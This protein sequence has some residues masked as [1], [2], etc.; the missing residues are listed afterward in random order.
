MCIVVRIS[1]TPTP[2]QAVFL[3]ATKSRRLSVFFDHT[4]VTFRSE[5][6]TAG[7][8]VL[9]TDHVKSL[10]DGLGRLCSLQYQDMNTHSM[11]RV[12]R[13]Y[14]QRIDEMERVLRF[15]FGEINKL[16]GTF[17]QS[18]QVTSF[19]QNDVDYHLD[20]VEDSLQK[21]YTQFEKFKVNNAGL[22]SERDS[23][24]ENRAVSRAA[25]FS[26]EPS[27]EDAEETLTLLDMEGGLGFSNVAGV[28][29]QEHQDKLQRTLYR[30]TRGNV[31]VHFEDVEDEFLNTEVKSEK[32]S[33]FVVYF[34]GSRDTIVHQKIH[35]ICM[36]FGAQLY[37]W[38]KTYEEARQLD[39]ELELIIADKTRALHAYEEFFLQEISVLLEPVRPEGNSLIEEWRLFCVKERSL[40]TTMDLF[41]STGETMRCDVWFPSNEDMMI[42]QILDAHPGQALLLDDHMKHGPPPTF[43]RTTQFTDAFQTFVDTYGIARYKEANPAVLTIVTLPFLFGIMFGDIGHGGVVLLFGIVLVL[44]NKTISKLEG[45][46]VKMLAGARYMILLMGFFA[47]FAGFLYN[48]FFS[49]GLDIFGTRYAAPPAA[50]GAEVAWTPNTSMSF[51]YPFGFD[52]VWKGAKNELLFFNSFKMK[53]AVIVA[54]VQMGVG[55]LIKGLNCVYFQDH[56]SFVFEFVPQLIFFTSFVGYMNF[57][58]FWKWLTPEGSNK[59]NIINTLINMGLNKPVESPMFAHQD[60]VQKFLLLGMLVAVPVM[61]LPKPLILKSLHNKQIKETEYFEQD[62]LLEMGGAISGEEVSDF[63][64]H[65]AA[66]RLWRGVHPP[67]DRN[68]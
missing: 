62:S 19:L 24:C 18:G 1:S 28:M 39:Q 7:T 10:L 64:V 42:R 30:T 65:Y 46:L 33:V 13:R 5:D 60:V 37:E 67:D 17:V 66:I 12:Y 49:L 54:G 56:L 50:E 25:A 29:L 15:L 3:A 47:T 27:R 6:M 36:A 32:K 11:R 59:P 2:P 52:P 63:S 4:M 40:Y 58:I 38:P 48:D 31:F 26:Y 35:R 9:P 14:I 55:V 43:F 53:F 41:E 20:V 16:H 44:L 23:A 21:L 34:Q 61:L 8:L 45:D 22:L 51:P 57:L 68:H